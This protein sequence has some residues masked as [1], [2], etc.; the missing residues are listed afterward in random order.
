MAGRKPKSDKLKTLT[1]NPGKR[2][3]DNSTE[4]L[5]VQTVESLPYPVYFRGDERAK[6]EWDRV[7]SELG[8]YKMLCS[9]DL[10]I[11]GVYCKSI[12][13]IHEAYNIQKRK[14]IFYEDNTGRM[15]KNPINAT[16][17]RLTTEIR[18]YSGVLGLN[19]SARKTLR[20]K[21]E[22]KDEK[23]AAIL[24]YMKGGAED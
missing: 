7:C 22:V 18:M 5:E 10:H 20:V 3:M 15:Y 2:P 11:L 14:G 13:Q 1:G 23:T 9:L 21:K 24:K 19:P 8:K 6:V 4:N 17:S 16:I 12:S